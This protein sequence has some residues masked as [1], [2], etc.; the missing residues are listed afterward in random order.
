MTASCDE[1]LERASSGGND[2]DR[3]PDF[4]AHLER[5][6]QCREEAPAILAAARAIRATPEALGGHPAADLIAAVALDPGAQDL[7]VHRPVVEHVASCAT[8][9]AEVREVRSAEQQRLSLRR[10]GHFRTES[11]IGSMGRALAT[12]TRG[13]VPARVALV[14]SLGVLVLAYPAFRG[15]HD[16]PLIERQMLDLERRTR[17]AEG[18]PRDLPL[19]PIQGG[20]LIPP[21]RWS[22]PVRL[23]ALTSPLRGQAP[24]QVLSVDP[25]EPYILVSVRPILTEPW[26][27]PDVH[28]F[29][30]QGAGGQEA[31]SSEVTVGEML[32]RMRSGGSLIFPIPSTLLAPGRY[33]LKVVPEKHPREPILQIPFEV[34]PAG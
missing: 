2:V 22:G 33:E 6:A 7:E 34:V 4:I 17:Q 32:Q 31:W 23:Q 29:I 5:C 24:Q 14:A 10:P 11:S 12:L 30:I 27:E 26:S 1:F 18:Q 3:Q 9:A 16:L 8:C 19:A 28:R 13:P 15:L 20:S 21:S 25:G